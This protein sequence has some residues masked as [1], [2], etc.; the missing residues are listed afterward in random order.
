MKRFLSI[1]LSIAV[2]VTLL[3]VPVFGNN[4]PTVTVESIEEAAAIGDEVKFEVSVSNNPGFTNSEWYV[5]YDTDRLELED[6]KYTYEIEIP[7]YGSLSQNYAIQEFYTKMGNASIG[8][9]VLA[10]YPAYATADSKLFGVVFTVKENAPSGEAKVWIESQKCNNDGVPVE[11][12]YVAGTVNVDGIDCDE[13]HDYGDWE[14]LDEVYHQRVCKNDSNHIETGEHSDNQNCPEC[15]YV[16]STTGGSTTGGSTTGG[17]TTGG[18]TTGGSTTGGSTTGGSTTG[19][20]TTGGSTTGG[21]TTGGSTTGGS[22]TGGSTTGG[23][24]TGGST[25]GGSTTGGSTTG[26]ST[27]GGS[28]TGGSTTGG[29]TTGGSTTGGCETGHSYGDWIKVDD[30]THKKVCGCGDTVTEAHT[31][32]TGIETTPAT[33]TTKGERT[34]TCTAIGCGATRTEDI[35]KLEGHTYGDWIKVDELT[36]KKVCACNDTVTEAHTWDDGV[37][38]TD[39]TYTSTGEKTYTCTAIG[40]GATRT[41]EVEKLPR[42]SSSSLGGIVTYTVDFETNGADKIAIQR[43]KQ[44]NL[45]N[46]PQDPQKEGYVFDGW[47]IDEDLTVLY[48]FETPVTKSFTLYA[49]WIQEENKETEVP[50]ETEKIS[51]N[52]VKETDWFYDAVQYV[53]SEN[54]MNGVLDNNF[55]PMDIL[56]R[57]QLVTVL[58]RIEGEPPVDRIIPFQ[59]VDL[60]SYYKN[61]VIWAQQN[62]IVNGIS[63]T[64]FA[65]NMNITREQIA[66]ILY[67][68]SQYKGYDVSAA[69]TTDIQSYQDA[70][71][72][73]EYA[74]PAMKYVVGVGLIRGRTNSTLNPKDY[75]TRA[76]IAQILYNFFK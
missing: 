69:E 14:P 31:W 61:A 47:Y 37:V 51:Y 11:F 38:T 27:T 45:V 39:P 18:S 75:A 64:E 50:G 28:T 54:I 60:P 30:L 65:P 59:D 56:T 1:F 33:H 35:D 55:A 21:S 58:Y 70:D 41:E 72:I 49:K 2:M 10:T 67:R 57:A 48:D 34:Y 13:G 76:E 3:V 44:R 40:C 24:T 53:T 4:L 22:T 52:D 46:K 71:E 23:S 7:G 16:A 19:G 42:P 66:A 73:S 32:D 29:S 6:F 8:K 12:T 36:H 43:I 74:I 20:S 63:D 62:G 17:T 5:K 26:G 9:I 68:Y 25:T 15:G